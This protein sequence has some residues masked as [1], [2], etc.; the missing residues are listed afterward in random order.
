V[1]PHWKKFI[2]ET[3]PEQ[4]DRLAW[5]FLAANDQKQFIGVR[6]FLDHASRALEQE[7][8]KL[9]LAKELLVP[10][11]QE[12]N[13]WVEATTDAAS[14]CE[15]FS[16]WYSSNVDDSWFGGKH[17]SELSFA[18]RNTYINLLNSP[19]ELFHHFLLV[20]ISHLDSLD[21]TRIVMVGES[22]YFDKYFED[23]R[24]LPLAVIEDYCG[25]RISIV[26]AINKFSMVVDPI[27]W[28]SLASKLREGGEKLN[29]QL[30]IPDSTERLFAER[31]LPRHSPRIR[32]VRSSK[33]ST[34]YGFFEPRTFWR[35]ETP[36]GIPGKSAHLLH[37][38]AQFDQRLLLIG[39]LPNQLRAL[40]KENKMTHI[41]ESL[42]LL[43]DSLFWNGYEIWKKRKAL[44]L[45]YWQTVAPKEWRV[46]YRNFAVTVK[47]LFIIV[48]DFTILVVCEEQ[49]V[50]VLIS[51]RK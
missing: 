42:D 29:C 47:T 37:K 8:K 6:H 15:L 27:I 51:K 40:A 9:E 26:L 24:V 45:R 38:I 30:S 49:S 3:E 20:A 25:S 19:V 14:S 5:D 12:L 11:V 41:E 18:S 17:S 13:L 44:V 16:E 2:F 33:E 4:I 43:R 1:G 7:R 48:K 23:R 10:L 21:P 46:N 50:L 31:V 39:I 32:G 34:V 28:S 36:I 22:I 35:K